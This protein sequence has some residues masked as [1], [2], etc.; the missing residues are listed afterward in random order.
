MTCYES[1]IKLIAD[2]LK[3]DN[4]GTETQ[5]LLREIERRSLENEKLKNEVQK[6]KLSA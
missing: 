5:L 1:Q 3:I 2:A 4:G 6:A